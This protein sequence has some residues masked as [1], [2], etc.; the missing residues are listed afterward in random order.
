MT[1]MFSVFGLLAFAAFLWFI[2]YRM[3]SGQKDKSKDKDFER[4]FNEGYH[5]GYCTGYTD[6]D[7]GNK[8]F[9]TPVQKRDNN[10]Y[11]TRY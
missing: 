6:R 8:A 2:V 3:D 9:E 5:K 7:N 4:G 11:M 10:T 1:D